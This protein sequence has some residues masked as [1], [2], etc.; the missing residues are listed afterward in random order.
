ML[1]GPLA[2][3]LFGLVLLAC[4]RTNISA[5]LRSVNEAGAARDAT[6]TQTTPPSTRDATAIQDADDVADAGDMAEDGAD[7]T[8]WTSCA[9]PPPALPGQSNSCFLATSGVFE[10]SAPPC[11]SAEYP[12]FCPLVPPKYSLNCLAAKAV[13]GGADYC[14][15][16]ADAGPTCVNV[17]LSTYD[18]SCR[19]DSDC[20]TIS[21][22]GISC[23][24]RGCASA[25]INVDSKTRYWQTIAGLPSC[26]GGGCTEENGPVCIQGVCTIE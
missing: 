16:C 18:R 13:D 20:F 22:S 12:M 19:S 4:G 14:C 11:G 25:A 21:T 2:S 23:C 5:S 8:D 3:A 15:P 24:I 9:V 6:A 1:T 26:A 10:Q 7:R 17:D